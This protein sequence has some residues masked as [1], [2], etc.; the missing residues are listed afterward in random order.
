MGRWLSRVLDGAKISRPPKSGADKTDETR[1]GV[2]SS[3]LSV[4]RERIIGNRDRR[5]EPSSDG[6]V[7]FV[8]ASNRPFNKIQPASPSDTVLREVMRVLAVASWEERATALVA[9]GLPS[10]W[11]KPFAKLLCGPPP[12]DY[13]HIYWA[14]GLPGANLFADEWATRAHALGWTSGEVFG[15]DELKPAARYDHKG[16][17][18]LLIDRAR[19]VALDERGAD[20]VTQQGSKQRFYRSPIKARAANMLHNE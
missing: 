9:V 7:S 13:D 6:S 12:G 14:R 8:S 4:G 11:A 17:A 2:V 20:I 3:V 10:E 18:W 1:E 5:R 19:V 15:L 16:V